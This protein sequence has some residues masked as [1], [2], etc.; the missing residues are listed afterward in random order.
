MPSSKQIRRWRKYLANE[1]AEA[2]TYRALA[3]NATGEQRDILCAVAEAE[4][5]HERYWEDM[6]GPYAKKTVQP[7]LET[8]ILG[9]LARRF[10]S[11]FTLA[12]LQAAEQRRPY[13]DDADATERLSADEKIHAEV[14]R[15]L[16]ATGREKLSGNFRAAVF[17]ANDG[18]VSNLALVIGM[19]GSGVSNNV[20]LIT[21]VSGLL[22]GALSMAAGEFV[23]VSS[24]KELLDVSTLDSST[25]SSA[26]PALDL[27]ENELALVF[28]ARGM[29]AEEATRYAHEA[30]QRSKALP[31]DAEADVFSG[32][33]GLFETRN[34]EV[35]GSGAA[36]AAASFCFFALGAL[37]PI[38]AFVFPLSTAVATVLSLVLVGGALMIT[39]GFVG[40]MSGASPMKRAL[41]QLALG[42]G[43]AVI[44]YLL[45][46]GFSFVL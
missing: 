24:Q 6:L 8:R 21:G 11:V 32:V 38:L 2:R 41:R 27:D 40:V 39:G 26:L 22:A 13:E 34:S 20:I 16:A 43:A 35:V 23:S 18:L 25:A 17:G 44:T 3:E 1:R 33:G 36:A 5:R 15:G 9:M 7:S 29:D 30:I 31:K 12:L 42:L 10:G 14:V 46:L 4:T 19:V 37:V 45:G 28:R